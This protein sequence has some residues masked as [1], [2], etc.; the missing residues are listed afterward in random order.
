MMRRLAAALLRRAMRVLLRANTGPVDALVYGAVLCW[1]A[2]LLFT[3]D[4]AYAHAGIGRALAYKGIWVWPALAAA[5]VTPAGWISDRAWVHHA[6][7]I[8]AVMWWVYLA[9]ATAI[10][11]PTIVVFWSL[12][13]L[14]AIGSFWLL[15]REGANDVDL[16]APRG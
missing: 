15:A 10:V 5:V 1:L 11:T 9:I 8:A 14:F 4:A 3:P 13:L 16:T 2:F 7:R 6:A 12:A